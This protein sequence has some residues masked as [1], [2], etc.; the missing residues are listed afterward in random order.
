MYHQQIPAQQEESEKNEKP[1]Q[2]KWR[3]KSERAGR[4]LSK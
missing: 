1:N 3:P 4:I 2:T